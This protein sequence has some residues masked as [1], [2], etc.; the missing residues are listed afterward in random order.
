VSGGR[1]PFVPV[2]VCERIVDPA[3]VV[4]RIEQVYRWVA[5]GQVVHS[6]PVAMRM[7]HDMPT[8]KSHSKAVII[9]P[10]SIAGLRIVAYRVQ[11]DGSGPSSPN[12]TRLVV[13]IDL[14]TGEP[15]AIVDE[16][17]NYTLRTAASVAV[18][19][20]HL[21][22]EQP[23]L[24]LIGTGGV[25]QAV[26]RMFAEVLR[27]EGVLVTSRSEESRAAF[28]SRLASTVPFEIRAVNSIADV[29][30]SCNLVVTATTT[31]SALIERSQVRNG[32]LLCA[33]GSYEL[34]PEIYRSADKVFVD[35]WKQ[36]ESAH[37]MAPLV[38]SGQ[39]GR[40][41]L[42]G[43]LADVVVGRIA[44]RE[45]ANEIIV[46]RTEGMASQDVAL[47]HWAYEEAERQGLVQD[48]TL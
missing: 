21:T 30:E 34:D 4:E 41:R 25:A 43:E 16:H 1:L 45:R 12:S 31:K 8:F 6:N 13:L 7:S 39:F 36:T 26:L 10:L 15:L 28:V 22:P 24:G 20:K 11:P 33:L 35:D 18:A 48:L 47:A 44:G 2:S 29:L 17:Y 5:D 46:V 9:P 37:D 42:S 32:M 40:D 27:L 14:E 38:R 19:A 3:L 23:V